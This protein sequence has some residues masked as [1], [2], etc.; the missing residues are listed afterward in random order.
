MPKILWQNDSYEK[1]DCSQ[2]YTIINIRFF[3]FDWPWGQGHIYIAQYPF[4]HVTYTPAKF[5]VD[6]FN[7]LG[8][9]TFTKQYTLFDLDLYVNVT[10]KVAQYHQHHVTYAPS[11]FEVATP[12]SLGGDAFARKYII[13][14]LI[15]TLVSRLHGM[16]PSTLYI[17][18]PMY[19]QSLKLLHPKVKEIQLQEMWWTHAQTDGRQ[20][21]FDSKLINLF[22]YLKSGCN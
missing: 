2:W 6:T 9:D 10:Q 22:F 16:F 3:T 14:P 21:K 20:T 5:E 19:L 15:F 8:G 7:S 13:W 4:H 18:W 12:N 1:L 17:M 11:K